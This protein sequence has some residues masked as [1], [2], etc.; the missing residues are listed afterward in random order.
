MTGAK[1]KNLAKNSVL[2]SLGIVTIYLTF[3]VACTAIVEAISSWFKLRSRNLENGMSELLEGEFKD[4][5]KVVEAFY[6]HPLIKTL[7]KGD[8]GRPSYI[9]PELVGKVVEAVVMAKAGVATLEEAIEDLPDG[10]HIKG[11]LQH[12]VQEATSSTKNF[13]QM[14]AEQFDATMERASGW[15]KRR[16]KWV[17]LGVSLVMVVVVNVDTIAIATALASNPEARTELV[18]LSNDRLETALTAE[19]NAAGQDADV[20]KQ[21]QAATQAARDALDRATTLLESAGLPL[22]WSDVTLASPASYFSKV[23]GLLVSAFAISLGAPFWFQVL[24]KFNAVRSTGESGKS[25]STPAPEPP[26]NDGQSSPAAAPAPPPS[27]T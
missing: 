14:V 6:R 25:A 24:Q 12:F 27:N 17:T 13:Q 4:G 3:A 11:L 22:G 10:S 7:S 16:T 21:A 19:T 5:E 23:I 26:H 15:F 8:R 18:K 1:V 20:V 2:D 9:S